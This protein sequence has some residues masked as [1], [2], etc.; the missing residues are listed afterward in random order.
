VYRMLGNPDGAADVTQTA[1]L[2]ALENIRNYDPN[3]KFFSWVYRIAINEAIDH[4]ERARRF[5]SLPDS[6]L[7]AS[8]DAA[9]GAARVQA[10]DRLQVALM[11]LSDDRVALL[12]GLKLRRDRKHSRR[13]G[14]D[15]EIPTV[16]RPPTLARAA[17]GGRCL[18]LMNDERLREL[19][20]FLAAAPVV[21]P[22]PDLAERILSGVRLPSPARANPVRRWWQFTISPAVL[23]YGVAAAVG[24]LFFAVVSGTH[25]GVLEVPDLSQV[26]GTLSS[27]AV[28][29]ADEVL[30]TL[31]LETAG[32]SSLARL[33]QHD[34]RL[35]LDVQI[36][37]D[38]PLRLDVEITGP[39]LAFEAVVQPPGGRPAIS[40]EQGRL[41][42]DGSGRLAIIAMLRGEAQAAGSGELRIAF[43]S[44]GQTLKEGVLRTGRQ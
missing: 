31:T 34:G 32:I 9:A 5:A 15:G 42:I 1:F 25:P 6:P 10:N 39:T 2:K 4:I 29:D 21:E 41:A 17:R 35:V 14:Q 11:S 18:F 13:A 38:R 22:P 19:D 36:D 8:D 30:D 27:D 33:R 7:V 12:H 16:H 26:V 40:M 23:G 43:S 28:G 20:E 37:S 3:F 44:E 24:A